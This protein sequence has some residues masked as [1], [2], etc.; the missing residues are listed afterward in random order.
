MV[1][2]SKIFNMNLYLFDEQV[3]YWEDAKFINMLLLDKK[4]Y[5]LVKNVSYLYDR[6]ENSSLS[7][8]AWN[9][10]SRY[11]P[12]IINNYKPLITYSIKRYGEVIKYIQYLIL[13]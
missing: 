2:K 7:K 13:N 6:N 5:G 4:K 3:N 1:F 12:H 10:K 9:F 8:V 11:A